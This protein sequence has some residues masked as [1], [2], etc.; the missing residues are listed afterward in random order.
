VDGDL[1]ATANPRSLGLDVGAS[2]G[3]IT[4]DIAGRG[5]WRDRAKTWRHR[6]RKVLLD[7][8]AIA[9]YTSVQFPRMFVGVIAAPAV[10]TPRATLRAGHGS[11][12]TDAVANQRDAEEEYEVIR[13]GRADAPGKEWWCVITAYPFDI[14]APEQKAEDDKHPA[15]PKDYCGWVL[16]NGVPTAASSAREPN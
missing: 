15:D 8:S 3:Y 1:E 2:A 11:H 5:I 6:A 7:L 9:A 13:K 14:R 12:G 4:A 16:A 10:R